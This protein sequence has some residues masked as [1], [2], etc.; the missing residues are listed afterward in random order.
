M[1]DLDGRQ[2]AEP[3]QPTNLPVTEGCIT[4]GCFTPESP[5]LIQLSGSCIII[6]I[7]LHDVG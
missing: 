3:G 5:L 4:E 6:R 7:K 1:R 2:S